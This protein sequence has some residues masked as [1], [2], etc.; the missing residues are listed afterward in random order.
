MAE[1]C[2]GD[3]EGSRPVRR[4]LQWQSRNVVKAC[5]ITGNVGENEQNMKDTGNIESMWFS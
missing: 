5:I 3:R 4:L 2:L 1:C